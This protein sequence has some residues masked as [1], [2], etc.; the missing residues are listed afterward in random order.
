M[1]IQR[2]VFTNE[3]F[4]DFVLRPE[5]ADKNFELH[6]GVLIEVP[7]P[8]ALHG[9]ISMRVGHFLLTYV[10]EHDLG[11]VVADSN[12]FDLAPGIV[13]K[14]DAAFISKTRLPEVPKKFELAP[15]LAVE[16]ISP[17]NTYIGILYKVEIYLRYGTRIV[18]VIYPDEQSVYVYTLPEEGSLK[19]RK[20][21]A[22]DMLDGGDVLP[23]FSVYVRQFF[24]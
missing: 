3:D 16:I 20:L 10:M 7:S 2:T 1:T 18:W 11:H 19:V 15:D 22:E 21:T 4:W 5:N 8:S 14:P 17:S 24:P 13:F 6:E 23:G 9:L 12:D